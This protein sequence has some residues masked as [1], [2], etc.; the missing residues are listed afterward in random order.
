MTILT[1]VGESTAPDGSVRF[2]PGTLTLLKQDAKSKAL[3]PVQIEVSTKDTSRVFT[4]KDPAWIYALQAAKTSITVW[5]IWLGHVYHWHIVT[6]A[7]QMTMYNRL[8]SDNKLW[9]LLQPQSQSLIDFDHTLLTLLWGKISPPTPLSGY[10]ALLE[11][12]DRFAAISP[13]PRR[14]GGREF[15]DDDPRVE[16]KNRG[17]DEADFTK[18]DAWDAYPLVGFLLEI[19]DITRVFVKAVVDDIYQAEGDPA[20]DIGLQKWMAAARNQ[21]EGNVRGIPPIQTRS[22]LTDVLTSILYR[23]TVHGAGSM[24]TVV[25]PTLS[26]V[27]NFP[28]CLQRSDIP[29][30]GEKLTATQLLKYL[31]HTG[32]IGGMTTFYF[33]FADSQPYMPLIPKGGINLH[34]YFPP[35]QRASND[36]LVKYRQRIHGFVDTYTTAWNNALAE[37]RGAPGPVP[38]YALNQYEQWPRSIEI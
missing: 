38:S 30:T 6:G 36:A 37:I 34:Q 12:L 9:D 14:S 3:T 31:P 8:P 1:S 15:F 20:N 4:S 35:T 19:Y 2:T 7:M 32:T 27:A 24:S 23:V 29:P 21:S 13:D 22:D 11:L 26:F 28:P 16:L 5:G 18:V 25:N 33:T 10:M 17:L